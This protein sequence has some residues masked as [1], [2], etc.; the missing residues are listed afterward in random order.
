MLL[1]RFLFLSFLFLVVSSSP[2]SFWVVVL[3][4]FLL[5]PPPLT[6]CNM[7]C[8]MRSCRR[9]EINYSGNLT[10]VF[11][12]RMESTTTRR[13]REKSSTST[14]TRNEE[15]EKAP[16]PKGGDTTHRR[17]REITAT[18]KERAGK[19]HLYVVVF[20]LHLLLPEKGRVLQLIN[21]IQRMLHSSSFWVVVPRSSPSRRC[22]SPPPLGCFSLSE[23]KPG[24]VTFII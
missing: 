10:R 16:P 1:F 17:K 3:F 24:K 9:V 6:W 4:P 21:L 2:S 18:H 8:L 12:S 11:F 22:S 13:R 5:L 15:A 23:G 20:P 7:C 19:H 14:T